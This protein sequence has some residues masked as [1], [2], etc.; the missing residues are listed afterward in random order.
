MFALAVAAV[1]VGDAVSVG[2][3]CQVYFEF[4]SNNKI[5]LVKHF[6]WS[7][8]KTDIY[9]TRVPVPV[10][11]CTRVPV[12]REQCKMVTQVLKLAQTSLGNCQ[13]FLAAK[14]KLHPMVKGAV[15][16]ALLWPTGSIIQQTL[17]GR[18]VSKLPYRSSSD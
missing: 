10:S 8:V 7:K 13:R 2:V 18:D 11:F 14:G 17:E 6:C 1:D 16:Y 15:T 3:C 9:I 12:N 5:S 4:K